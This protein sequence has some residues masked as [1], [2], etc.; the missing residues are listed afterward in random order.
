LRLGLRKPLIQRCG[1]GE[2]PHCLMV[3]VENR[4]LRSSFRFAGD[5]Q[6]NS[7][8]TPIDR[9]PLAVEDS[10]DWRPEYDDMKAARIHNNYGPP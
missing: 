3:T 9:P 5:F 8:V 4:L 6:L 7:D 1:L 10:G 2:I